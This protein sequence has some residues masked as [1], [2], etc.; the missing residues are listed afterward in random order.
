MIKGDRY[1]AY[2]M[3][4]P[5]QRLFVE[6]TRVAK[7]G[8]WA[9]ITVRTWAVMWSKRQK[10]FNAEFSPTAETRPDDWTQ[11]DID[12]QFADYS[13]HDRDT[14]AAATEAPDAS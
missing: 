9:D 7:D 8:T 1:V 4:P 11:G 10:L 6:V 13:L 5:R 2:P 3:R 14:R 12:R